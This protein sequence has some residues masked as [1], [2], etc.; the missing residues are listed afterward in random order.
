MQLFYFLIYSFKTTQWANEKDK[1]R[2]IILKF[3]LHFYKI[4][5]FRRRFMELG[6]LRNLPLLGLT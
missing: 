6:T 2:K 3:L 1:K 5:T 4:W